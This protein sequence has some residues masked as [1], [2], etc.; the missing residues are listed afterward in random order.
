[1]S[2]PGRRP[3]LQDVQRRRQT[4][5]TAWVAALGLALG[6]CGPDEAALVSRID[7]SATVE[8]LAPVEGIDGDCSRRFAERFCPGQYES[9]G[10]IELE[11]RQERVLGVFGADV[12]RCANLVWLRVVRLDGVGPVPDRGSLFEVPIRIELEYGAGAIHAV[13]FPQGTV[14]LDQAGPEDAQQAA[15]PRACPD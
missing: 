5:E 10:A 8:V 3:M 4:A 15:P 1:M 14:R 2:S 13:A 9:L 6:A 12:D 7:Q 11:P